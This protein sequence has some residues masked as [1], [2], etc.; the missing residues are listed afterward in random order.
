MTSSRLMMAAVFLLCAAAAGA[1]RLPLKVFTTADGLPHNEIRRIVRDSRGFLWFCTRDG[2]SRFDGYQFTNFGIDEGL[3]RSTV[4]DLIEARDGTLWVATAGGLV[5]FDPRGVPSG[6]I[7]YVGARA[8]SRHPMFAVVS[9][10]TADPKARAVNRL[11]QDR[12]GMIWCAT[13]AG[14]QRLD[15]SGNY[16]R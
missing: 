13:D 5:A 4:N 7:A 12:H 8:S 2:L 1:E 14:L 10:D 9:P 15:R 11:M 6:G 3:P 16:P